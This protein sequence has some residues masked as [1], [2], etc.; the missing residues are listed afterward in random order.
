[1]NDSMATALKSIF[2]EDQLRFDQESLQTY[3][4]DWTRFYKV[5]PSAIVFPSTT[6]QVRDLVLLARKNKWALVPSGGRTGLSGGAVASHREIVVSMERMN[7]ILDFDD[8]DLTLKVEAGVIT[9]EIQKWAA[10]KNLFYPVD[11]AA[12]G[13]SHIGGNVATNAGGIK[14]VRYGLTRDWVVGLTVVTGK[15]EVLKLNQ[16]LIKNAS[17]YDLRHLFVGSEGTLGF[18]TEVELKLAQPPLP[19][20]VM[21]LATSN[22]KNLMHIFRQS[23]EQLPITAFEMFSEL[24]LQKV[25]AHHSSLS[26]PFATSAPYY[27]LV[28]FEEKSADT[29]DK[30]L[31][32]FESLLESGHIEDGILSQSPTQAAELWKLREYISESLAPFT[33]YKNDI[34]VRVSKATDFLSAADEILKKAYPDYEVVWFGHIGDGNLHINILRPKAMAIEEFVKSCRGADDLLYNLIQDYQGSISAEHGVGL[35]KRSFLSKARSQE[36]IEILRSIKKIF[37]PDNII[38]P[39][40]LFEPN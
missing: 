11:F 10:E 23:R 36:E 2:P 17:G 35:T 27:V 31:A 30:A 3:G 4:R 40:K 20:H 12:R 24:A 14:V 1:M 32:L 5:D 33:P 22:L 13:S 37:D 8:F 15:G 39:G 38:N 18:I 21:V 29:V 25:L 9:E 6:E 19:M 16:S 7:R 34:S 26:R 28:E